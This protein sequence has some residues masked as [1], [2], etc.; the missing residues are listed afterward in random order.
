[1][2]HPTMGADRMSIFRVVWKIIDGGEY[3]PEDQG[4]GGGFHMDTH[5]CDIVTASSGRRARVAVKLARPKATV[6]RKVK[7]LGLA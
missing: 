2:S 7:D 3:V 1:M 4:G 6:E 5:G